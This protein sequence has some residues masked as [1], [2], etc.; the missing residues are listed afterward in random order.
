[1]NVTILLPGSVEDAPQ[2]SAGAH[3]GGTG[4]PEPLGTRCPDFPAPAVRGA[5]NCRAA[6]GAEAGTDP[7]R[8][9][10]SLAAIS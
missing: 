1:M 4:V 5:G 3:H 9:G 2:P 7:R 6:A 8:G 10:R